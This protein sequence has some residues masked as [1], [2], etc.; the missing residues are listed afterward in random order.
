LPASIRSRLLFYLTSALL[1]VIAGV[2]GVT[3]FVALRAANDAYDRA[4][5]DPVL[6]IA[7]HVRVDASGVHLDL[8]RNALEA[9]VYDQVDRLYYQVRTP[10]GEVVDGDPDLPKPVELP[11]GEHRFFDARHHG[12]PIRVAALQGPDGTIVEVGETLHKR[13]QLVADIVTAEVLTLV[14]IAATAIILSW[15]GIANGLRPL[16]RLRAE[17]LQRSSRDLRPLSAVASP[18][19]IAPLVDAF[20][21]LLQ[22]LREASAMQQRFMANAAHQLRTPLAGLQMHLELLLRQSLAPHVRTE[23][24]GLHGATVRASRLASQLLALAKAETGP[25]KDRPLELVDLRNVAGEAARDFSP[26]AIAGD[27]DLGFS[28]DPAVIMGDRTLLPEIFNNLIDNALRYTPRGGAITVRTGCDGD[29]PYLAV[30][31][32]GPGIP[33]GERANVMERFYRMSGTPGDGSG[34]GLAIVKEAVE[35]LGGAVEILSRADRPGACVRVTFPALA[36]E[37]P[38]RAAHAEAPSTA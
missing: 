22:Q 28:L 21:G 26:R 8:T 14:A 33:P 27:I 6:A 30:E 16:Q 1:L 10:G 7:E 3:Y 15:I 25:V 2:A 37:L 13:H 19:E 11:A 4:L 31:D 32:T 9:L 18:A 24:E 17:L 20:N 12:E 36:A 38:R 23:V 34:L 35:R 29:T 5:L